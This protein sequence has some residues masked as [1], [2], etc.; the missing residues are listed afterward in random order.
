MKQDF[1][2]AAAKQI[3]MGDAATAYV[4]LPEN[5][6]A[7]S[8]IGKA[9]IHYAS[10]QSGFGGNTCHE[11]DMA[12]KS[13]D[14]CLYEAKDLVQKLPQDGQA[15]VVVFVHEPQRFHFNDCAVAAQLQAAMQKRPGFLAALGRY[16]S[17]K[18][19]F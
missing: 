13:P 10:S 2:Y 4:F 6:H 12:T 11:V 19:A 15:R 1:H 16:L 5:D 9:S 3:D 7:P 17:P 18:P 8:A 14:D